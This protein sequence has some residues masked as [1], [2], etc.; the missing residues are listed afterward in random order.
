MF[1]C[2]NVYTKKNLDFAL[3]EKV[4]CAKEVHKAFPGY[5]IIFGVFSKSGFT[6]RMLDIAKEN[7]GI[8]LIHEDQLV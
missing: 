5:E 3:K 1:Y 2:T 8:F 7:A 4:D 6:K